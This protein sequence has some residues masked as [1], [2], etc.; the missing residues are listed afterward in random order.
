MIL[1]SSP[2]IQLAKSVG[3]V[4]L[5][6][7]QELAGLI[8]KGFSLTAENEN[9]KILATR[10][11]L[12]NIS[13]REAAVENRRL[14]EIVGFLEE[15][16]LEMVVAMVI[17]RRGQSKAETLVIN[18]GLK[19]GFRKNATVITPSGLVGYVKEAFPSLSTV[20]LIT[21]SDVSV[22]ALDTRSRILGIIRHGGM[23]GFIFDYLPLHCDVAEGDEIITSGLGGIFPR[24]IRIGTVTSVK[25]VKYELFKRVMIAPAV[26]F[27]NI[28]DI[29]VLAGSTEE[30]DDLIDNQKQLLLERIIQH[31]GENDSLADLPDAEA[32]A[33]HPDD[34][35]QG[36]PTLE[37][38]LIEK[39]GGDEEIWSPLANPESR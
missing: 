4:L 6:P 3:N 18:K 5:A 35:K 19:D 28:E 22:A 13:L 38:E 16:K 17:G 29:L 11:A 20:Q 25:E 31:E 39:I 26:N 10:L 24:G 7:V 34:A 1:D 30:T 23:S 14:R 33:F 36:V 21:G 9:L 37:D 27:H 12:E 2:K 32:D 8:Q 15:E